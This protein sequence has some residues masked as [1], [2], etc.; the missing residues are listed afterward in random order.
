MPPR[1]EDREERIEVE[2]PDARELELEERRLARIR[3]HGVDAARTD[4]GVVEDVAAGAGDGEHRVGGRE[5]ECA[6]V[7]GRILPA[8]VV[9]E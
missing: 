5:L 3:V 9:D 2:V 4:Q 1:S 8:G 6:P 7:D